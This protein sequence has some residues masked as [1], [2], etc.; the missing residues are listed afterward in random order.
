VTREHDD[1]DAALFV[2]DEYLDDSGFTERV[3]AELPRP[4]SF[5]LRAAIILGF[6]AVAAAVGAAVLPID[7]VVAGLTALDLTAPLTL[8]GGVS[9]LAVV[10]GAA[11]AASES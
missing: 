2:G 1:I 6:T 10:G 9:L 11:V 5:R 3:V 8:A 4:P 7:A